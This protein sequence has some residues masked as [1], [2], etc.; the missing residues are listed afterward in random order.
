MGYRQAFAEDQGLAKGLNL[1][2]GKIT[3]KPVAEAHGMEWIEWR[4]AV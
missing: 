4:K 1:A 2:K 3:C